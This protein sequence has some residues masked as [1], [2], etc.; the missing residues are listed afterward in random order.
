MFTGYGGPACC[1][2]GRPAL[3]RLRA[4]VLQRAGRAELPADQSHRAAAG[5]RPGR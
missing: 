2:Q 5:A 1:A 3:G 4:V